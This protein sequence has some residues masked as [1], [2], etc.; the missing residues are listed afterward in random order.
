MRLI[1]FGFTDVTN[2]P[3]QAGYTDLSDVTVL[4]GPNDSGKSSTL[5]LL[6]DALDPQPPAQL[7]AWFGPPPRPNLV[8]FV[9]CSEGERDLLLTSI[10]DPTHD[11]D[12]EESSPSVPEDDDGWTDV[13]IG[14]RARPRGGVV[15]CELELEERLGEDRGR[16]VMS[17]LQS[18]RVFAFKAQEL[19]D[20]P[21]TLPQTGWSVHWCIPADHTLAGIASEGGLE[22]PRCPGAAPIPVWTTMG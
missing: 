22:G 16:L 3:L 20:Q 11:P 5:A 19:S 8:V 1:G 4:I 12:E 9:V 21:L 15:Q 18:T 2:G 17:A 10:A 7:D 13:Y 6:A 14:P